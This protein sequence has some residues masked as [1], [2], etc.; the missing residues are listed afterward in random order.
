MENKVELSIIVP[1]YNTGQYLR[2]C[3]DSLVNQ[4]LKEIEIIV[5]NDCSPDNSHEIIEEYITKYNNIVYVNHEVNKGYGGAANSALAVS[6]GKYFTF[7][8]SDDYVIDKNC[9]KEVMEQFQKY[10]I[11]VVGFLV[12]AL[13]DTD[14]SVRNIFEKKTE[15]IVKFYGSTMN[16]IGVNIWNKVFKKSDFIDNG[17]V[18]PEKTKYVD[19]EMGYKYVAKVK[20]EGKIINKYFYMYR[21]FRKGSVMNDPSSAA[22]FF[23][24]MNRT[25]DWLVEQG[26]EKEYR[27]KI[28]DWLNVI[29]DLLDQYSEDSHA[30]MVEHFTN[31]INK[32]QLK[33]EEVNDILKMKVFAYCIKDNYTRRLYLDSIVLYKRKQNIVNKTKHEIKRII[34]QIKTF[35]HDK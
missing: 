18:F 24:T 35:L 22:A 5:V 8:D 12:Q 25:Y 27:D 20:P 33:P 16:T 31:W 9:Y 1:V 28:I 34:K 29:S 21:E 30:Y 6:K 10:N 19:L 26:V 7:V 11:N 23:E 32:I 2:Q 4:T 15:K 3:L 17:I 13:N 14:K